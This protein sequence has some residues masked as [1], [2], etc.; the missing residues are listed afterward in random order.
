MHKT[1]RAVFS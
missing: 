1:H